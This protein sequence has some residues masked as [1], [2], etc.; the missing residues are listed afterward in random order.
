MQTSRRRRAVPLILA[1]FVAAVATLFVGVRPAL[2]TPPG[3]PIQAP[4]GLCTTDE[5]RNPAN[6]ERCTSGLQDLGA[7]RL[8]CVLAPTPSTPD[9]GTAGWFAARSAAY[10]QP[11]PKGLSTRYGY[12][13]YDY[14][15]YDIGCAQ[16][17]MH[18]DYKFENTVANGE[19]MMATGVIG[20]AN[21]LRERAWNPKSMW[22][23]A[24]PL[25]DKATKAVYVKVFTVFGAITLAVVGL[26]LL[27]RSRQSD[28]S[29][30]MTTA[31]WAVLVMVIITAI[32]HWPTWSANVADS[33]LVGSLG[34][35]HDAVGPPSQDTPA[36]QCRNPDPQGCIDHRSPAI[37][38]SDTATDGMLYRNWLRGELGSA[39]SA[40]ARRYGPVL[41]DAKSFTWGEMQDIRDDPK[42]RQVLIDQK[43]QRWMK[44]A[45]Q[46]KADDPEAYEY[47]QGTRGMDR[48]GAGFIAILA[49]LFFAMFDITASLL[50]L[51]GFLI[52]RWAVIAA[53]ILGTVG[54]LRPA[55]SGLRRL[56]NAVVAAIFNIII[57]GTGAAVY[58]FAV[59]LV[60]GTASLPGWLQ[61]VLIWLTG[62]VG[63]LLLRPYRRI[64]QL[65]GKDSSRAV[66]SVGSWH[67]MFFRDV[68]QA[69][70]FRLVE[71]GGTREPGRRGIFGHPDQRPESRTESVVTAGSSRSA[72][73]IG[74]G[75][76]TGDPGAPAAARP[77]TGPARGPATREA[78]RAASSPSRRD[79]GQRWTEPDVGDGPP[80]Y[81]VY[82]PDSGDVSVPARTVRRT[83]SA[84][85]PN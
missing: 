84:S 72:V 70:V 62:V 47:L 75:P 68:Q 63:W 14:T 82:R 31:G 45:E 42:Q 73:A 24:D 80:S 76:S 22:G 64:T 18:P 26:Y 57:F 55:S 1:V 60:M 10:D 61:V 11:G 37:R 32:A 29:N 16:T 33:T 69:A 6:F 7:S 12:A 85:T 36:A 13:G 8:Q 44:V 54:L 66:T 2:A 83:E 4:A 41:Y 35:I 25:V 67:R 53:P 15:T 51:L 5:W 9:S 77:E 34:V 71:E 65:G 49:S 40:T 59:D 28:M 78:A 27:W 17:V 38:A 3:P 19:F 21:A 50:V 43:Q 30:A 48:I 58:L 52:F 39:D 79:T 23:W 56:A 81:T 46:I 74:P 20:A